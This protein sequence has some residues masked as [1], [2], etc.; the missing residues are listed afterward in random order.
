MKCKQISNY[1]KNVGKYTKQQLQLDKNDSELEICMST[2]QPKPGSSFN[3]PLHHPEP[4]IHENATQKKGV[5]HTE[6]QK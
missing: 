1:S 6:Q 3:L 4:L 2:K 5:F